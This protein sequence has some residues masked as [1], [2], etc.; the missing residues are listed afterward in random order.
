MNCGAVTNSPNNPLILQMRN[1]EVQ[2]GHSETFINVSELFAIVAQLAESPRSLDSNPELL[3]CAM[4]P[5]C[6][7]YNWFALSEIDFFRTIWRTTCTLKKTSKS[8][9]YLH[10]DKQHHIWRW[11]TLHISLEKWISRTVKEW[12]KVMSIPLLDSFVG[13]LYE[14]NWGAV[15]KKPYP[16]WDKTPR[17]D[18]CF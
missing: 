17:K 9:S 11:R 2:K 6:V 4:L 7:K 8:W 14:H 10:L 18:R 13:F 15:P 1:L 16:K 12:T 3:L 5:W